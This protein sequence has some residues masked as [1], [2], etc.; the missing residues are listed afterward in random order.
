MNAFEATYSILSNDA[1]LSYAVKA[2]RPIVLNQ[3]DQ[4]PAIVYQCISENP[5]ISLDGDSGNLD[6]VRMQV[7]SWAF[8]MKEAQDVADLVRDAMN[9]S[10]DYGIRFDGSS[11]TYEQDTKRFGVQSDYLLWVRPKNTK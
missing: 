8:S 7:D 11:Y 9:A 5:T 2:I 1:E 6:S 3:D 10:V 4:F